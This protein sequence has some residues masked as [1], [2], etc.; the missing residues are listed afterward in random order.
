[1]RHSGNNVRFIILIAWLVLACP[2]LAASE[3]LSGFAS[4]DTIT[5]RS[6]EAWEDEESNIIHFSGGFELKA[7][8][9]Y[10]SADFATLYGK[11]DDPETAVITGSPAV[12]LINTESQGRIQTITGNAES[13]MYHRDSNSLQMEGDAILTR[14]D[15]S[16]QSGT[17]QYDIGMDRISASGDGG[18][19]IRVIPVD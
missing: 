10:L 8:E 15:N 1:M 11:L 4:G 16:I 7:S 13:I 19:R 12:I 9:W 2:F 18:V 5:I 3:R 14:D 17:I 6:A